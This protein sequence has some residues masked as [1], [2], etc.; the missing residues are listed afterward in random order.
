[1][2]LIYRDKG[3]TGTQLAIYSHELCIVSVRKEFTSIIAGQQARWHWTFGLNTAIPKGVPL[4][5]AAN[6]LEE[7][8]AIIE[9]AWKD[10]LTAAG[11]REGP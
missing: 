7:A 11:L 6:S 9:A 10:W 2:P 4:H 1:M 8:K 5:G 3:T